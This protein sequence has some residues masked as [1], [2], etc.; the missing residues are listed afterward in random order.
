MQGLATRK[1]PRHLPER[2]LF[3]LVTILDEYCNKVGGIFNGEPIPTAAFPGRSAPNPA[4]VPTF[5][6]GF[7]ISRSHPRPAGDIILCTI[8]PLAAGLRLTTVDSQGQ[9]S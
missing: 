4:P 6:P 9:L 1:L 2:L 3:F 8:G 5:P 7:A